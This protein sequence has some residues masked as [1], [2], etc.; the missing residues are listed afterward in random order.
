MNLINK[1]TMTKKSMIFVFGFQKRGMKEKVKETVIETLDSN[2]C[3]VA[4]QY[5]RPLIQCR[6]KNNII[7]MK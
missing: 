4:P 3:F 7:Y 1:G 2:R 5:L 6:Y